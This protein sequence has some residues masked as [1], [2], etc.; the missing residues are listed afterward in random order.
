MDICCLTLSEDS[1]SYMDICCFT[2]SIQHLLF[3]NGS[4]AI[5]PSS[6]SLRKILLTAQNKK[7]KAQTVSDVINTYAECQTHV[8]GVLEGPS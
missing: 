3:F 5:L 7:V 4:T 8:K 2:L 1:V 6:D